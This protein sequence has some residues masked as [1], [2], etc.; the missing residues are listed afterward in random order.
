VVRRLV[1]DGW[2]TRVV[3]V[4][5]GCAGQLANMGRARWF[6]L[7]DGDYAHWAMAVAAELTP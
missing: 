7:W 5:V 2:V 6:G 4:L 3:L 1:L